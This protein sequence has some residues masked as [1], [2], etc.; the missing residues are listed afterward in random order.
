MS[1]VHQPFRIWF[2][3]SAYSMF[4]LG[5]ITGFIEF[6]S[7]NCLI[8]FSKKIWSKFFNYFITT[9]CAEMCNIKKSMFRRIFSVSRLIIGKFSIEKLAKGLNRSWISH[10]NAKTKSISG[11]NSSISRRSFFDSDTSFAINQSSKIFFVHPIYKDS[12]NKHLL[13]ESFEKKWMNSWNPKSY[14]YGNH[15]PSRRYTFGRCR[16]YLRGLVLLI[17]GKSV[18][19]ESDDIVR[20]LWKHK[21]NTLPENQDASTAQILFQGN[22]TCS[23]RRKLG[24]LTVSA[25]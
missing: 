18:H 24:V 2:S 21:V 6:H 12:T 20:S 1:Q 13:Q 7:K 25:A 3:C 10:F 11:G 17:T 9:L 15:E 22:L 4:I 8:F 14:G 16:D 5:K 23:N 19:H